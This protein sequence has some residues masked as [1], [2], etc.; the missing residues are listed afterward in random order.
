MFF[1]HLHVITSREASHST[2]LSIGNDAVF[3]LDHRARS[4]YIVL[5]PLKSDILV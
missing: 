1:R 3:R 2:V 4:L 5:L